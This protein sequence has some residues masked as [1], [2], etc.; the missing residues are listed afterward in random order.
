MYRHKYQQIVCEVVRIKGNSV[1][2]YRFEHP[3]QYLFLLWTVCT[4]R[5]PH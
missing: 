2:S 3:R 1:M 4:T 5:A